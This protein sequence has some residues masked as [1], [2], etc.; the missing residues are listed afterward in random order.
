M[1]SKK[2]RGYIFTLD[3]VVAAVVVAAFLVMIYSYSTM[4]Y[5]EIGDVSMLRSASDIT[6]VLY[7][8]GV[9]QTLDNAAI[10]GSLNSMLPPNMKMSM[11]LYAYGTGSVPCPETLSDFSFVG[12]YDSTAGAFVKY[13]PEGDPR[14]QHC[15][16]YPDQGGL[17][18]TPGLES[19]LVELWCNDIIANS[20]CDFNDVVAIFLLEKVDGGVRASLSRDIRWSA[21]HTDSIQ[22]RGSFGG[23]SVDLEV[24]NQGGADYD[25]SVIS[26]GSGEAENVVQVNDDITGSYYAGKWEFTKMSGPLIENNVLVQY[27]VWFK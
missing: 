4:T 8:K 5:T 13:P 24:F 16:N 1:N 17:D 19:S 21:G 7:E 6:K 15:S 22:V 14:S 18:L 27:K 9:L 12:C 2:L 20:D 26:C 3:A 25:E 23:Q 10:E 11:T